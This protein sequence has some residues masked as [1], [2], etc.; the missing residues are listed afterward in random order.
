[1]L[2]TPSIFPMR[3]LTDSA[4]EY[5]VIKCPSSS[6]YLRWSGFSSERGGFS[7]MTDKPNPTKDPEFQKTLKNLLSMKPKPHSEMKLGKKKKR[8]AKK[9]KKP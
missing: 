3:A 8:A 4:K 2:S 1:V 9:S 5:S 6:R 7:V